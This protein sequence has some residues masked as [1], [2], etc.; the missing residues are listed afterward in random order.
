MTIDILG[1]DYEIIRQYEN[2]NSKLKEAN[3]LCETW[4]K[5][6]VIEI[7]EDDPMNVENIDAF[8]RKVLRHEIVHA[9]LF[10]S[11]LSSNSDWARNEEVVDW[12]ALQ[13]PKI[14]DAINIVEAA[15]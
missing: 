8:E 1:T 6:I 14:E 5:K 2:E 3:G 10:E 7:P 13:F 9:F 12:I 15:R 4:S 11:G